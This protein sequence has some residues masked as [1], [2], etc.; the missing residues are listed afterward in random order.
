MQKY[1]IFVRFKMLYAL[2]ILQQLNNN[3]ELLSYYRVSLIS[4]RT[5]YLY[6]PLTYTWNNIIIVIITE[7]SLNKFMF[8]VFSFLQN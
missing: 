1:F 4:T 2:L 3:T 8:Y 6:D 7:F 5:V